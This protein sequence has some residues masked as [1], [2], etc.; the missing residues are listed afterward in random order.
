MMHYEL[1]A[2]S[3]GSVTISLEPQIYCCPQD[4]QIGNIT[5][6]KGFHLYAKLDYYFIAAT[7]KIEGQGDTGISADVTLDKI[8]I[9]HGNFLSITNE[10][11]E[12]GPQFTMSTYAQGSQPPHISISGA[13]QV[14]GVNLPSIYLDITEEGVDFDIK[15]EISSDLYFELTGSVGDP[16]NMNLDGKANVQIE[17]SDESDD[18]EYN[19]NFTQ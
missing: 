6:T 7:V 4:T 3:D 9:G 14:M 12:T 8:I 5:Y 2:C 15:E 11:G 10:T 1:N 19:S 18:Y 16:H 17:D 13:V